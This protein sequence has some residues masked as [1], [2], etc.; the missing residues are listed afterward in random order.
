MAKIFFYY[1]FVFMFT[2]T[3][4]PRI[5]Q[6]LPSSSLYRIHSGRDREKN[7][8]RT[9]WEKLHSKISYSRLFL[10]RT[11]FECVFKAIKLKKK[12]QFKSGHHATDIEKLKPVAVCVSEVHIMKMC[13]RFALC[14]RF[15][16]CM[17]VAIAKKLR[18][19]GQSRAKLIS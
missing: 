5:V 7:A 2:S 1:F 11:T 14:M 13:V 12:K 3:F 10:N 18:P 8:K 19:V 17:N 16:L 6:V 4:P 15:S 9:H